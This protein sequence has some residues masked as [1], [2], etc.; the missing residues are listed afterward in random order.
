MQDERMG[1]R[2]WTWD[3]EFGDDVS[4]NLAGYK[5]VANDGEIGHVDDL[6]REVG[7]GYIVVDTGG[8]IMGHKSMI[9]AAAIRNVNTE[10][11]TVQVDLTK[12]EIKGAP[13]Y[14]EPAGYEG[15]AQQG[16]LYYGGLGGRWGA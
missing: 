13:E 10:S 4:Q 9:P 12:D 1:D 14:D 15:Y 6:S 11:E 2:M 5:V 16:G 3:D 7:R 8:W